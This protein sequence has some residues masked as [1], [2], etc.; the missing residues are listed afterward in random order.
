VWIE[1][2]LQGLSKELLPVWLAGFF[3]ALLTGHGHQQ[4]LAVH[5]YGLT[6]W[7]HGRAMESTALSVLSSHPVSRRA[8]ANVRE[9][10]PLSDPASSLSRSHSDCSWQPSSSGMPCL[11]SFKGETPGSDYLPR[12]LTMMTP[13]SASNPPMIERNV[14]TSRSHIQA[15][16]IARGGERYRKLVAIDAGARERA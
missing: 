4:I 6:T 5:L 7:R 11:V 10:R 14:G 9:V 3:E 13:S 8:W 12:I 1:S 2:A 16:R 15:I